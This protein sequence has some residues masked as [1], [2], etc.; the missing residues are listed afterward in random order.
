M[1]EELE[2]VYLG[3]QN[4]FLATVVESYNWLLYWSSKTHNHSIQQ[5]FPMSDGTSFAMHRKS[6]DGMNH[7]K[8][9]KSHIV[10]LRCGCH[11]H[12]TSECDAK[13][14]QP[15]KETEGHQHLTTGV[16]NAESQTSDEEDIDFVFLMT[17]E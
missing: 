2:N 14:M 3:S 17:G 10:C 9:D 13:M 1:I 15:S 11:S 12:Y 5:V 6:E 8:K 16:A 7:A 4:N